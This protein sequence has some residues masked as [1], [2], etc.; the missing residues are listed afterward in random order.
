MDIDYHALDS[1][2]IYM[3]VEGDAII[4]YDEEEMEVTITKGEIVLIPAEI[5]EIHLIPKSGT[6]KMLEV[7]IE[8]D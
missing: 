5:N 2:V 3:M 1:F 4:K 7:F 8:L 6:A